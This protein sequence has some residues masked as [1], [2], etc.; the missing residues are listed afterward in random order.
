MHHTFLL[1]WRNSASGPRPPHYRRFMITL[2]HTTL[3]VGLP[4]RVIRP[5]QRSLSDNTQQS[6]QTDIH[7]PGGIRTHNSSK[8]AAE[9]QRLRPSSGATTTAVA[10]SGLPSELGDK[11]AVGRGRVGPNTI[12]STATPHSNG[13][14]IGCYCSC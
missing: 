2:R 5:T 6:Q 8:R 12:N 7:A 1:A 14:N 4:G 3:S 10:A 9:D 13:K 11:S